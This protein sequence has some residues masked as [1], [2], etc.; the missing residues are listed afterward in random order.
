M[1]KRYQQHMLR[2]YTRKQLNYNPHN[3]RDS[4]KLAVFQVQITNFKMFFQVVV[5]G[6][7]ASIKDAHFPM[8][9]KG[10]AS[11]ERLSIFTSLKLN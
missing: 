2:K 4:I 8:H 6:K 7:K 10:G 1:H 9:K 11:K 3:P 5:D